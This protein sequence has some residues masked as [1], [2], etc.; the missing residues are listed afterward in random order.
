MYGYYIVG[1]VTNEARRKS[2]IPLSWS[3]RWLPTTMLVLGRELVFSEV[4]ERSLQPQLTVVCRVV[5][6][7]GRL[8]PAY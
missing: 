7:L 4:V 8:L 2:Q 6:S 5:E 1:L 3:Y